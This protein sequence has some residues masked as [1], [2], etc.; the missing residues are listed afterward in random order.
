M[1]TFDGNFLMVIAIMMVTFDGNFLMGSMN[2]F[3]RV[4]GL[5]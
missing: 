2:V 3:D 5:Y 1:V 4:E